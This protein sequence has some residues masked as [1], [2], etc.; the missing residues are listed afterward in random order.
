MFR[1]QDI[2]RDSPFGS[3]HVRARTIVTAILVL[4]LWGGCSGG[5]TVVDTPSSVLALETLR[6]NPQLRRRL[7]L[8]MR[9]AQGDGHFVVTSSPERAARS[10]VKAPARASGTSRIEDLASEDAWLA[11]KPLERRDVPATLQDAIV[12]YENAQEA[13]DVVAV[14]SDG[15]M[16]E[17]QI[18]RSDAAPTTTQ[19]RLTHGTG[20]SDISMHEGYV[21]ARTPD[22]RIFARTTP[23]VAYDSSQASLPVDVTLEPQ[24][25]D[26]IASVTVDTSNATFPVALD[27]EWVAGPGWPDEGLVALNSIL[28]EGGSNVMVGDVAVIDEAPGLMLGEREL[29]LTDD[30]SI[31]GSVYAH[32]VLIESE[33]V[34]IDNDVFADFVDCDPQ[35]QAQQSACYSWDS[36]PDGLPVQVTTPAFPAFAAGTGSETWSTWGTKQPGVYGDVTIAADVGIYLEPGLY[37]MKSLTVGTG[38]RLMLHYGSVEVRIE[39]SLTLADTARFY[40]SY[41]ADLEVFV[42]GSND[43]PGDPWSQPRAVTIG[44]QTY[45]WGRLFAPNGTIG[46]ETSSIVFGRLVGRDV[47]VGEDAYIEADSQPTLPDCETFCQQVMTAG[48]CQDGPQDQQECE[49][50]CYDDLTTGWCQQQKQMFVNCV[51]AAATPPVFTCVGGGGKPVLSPSMAC[52]TVEADFHECENVCADLPDDPGDCT[53]SECHCSPAQCD[54]QNP[55]ASWTTEPAPYGTSCDNG[56]LCD[57]K[58]VCNGSGQCQTGTAVPVPADQPPCV[59]YTCDAATGNV[60]TNY[61]TAACNDGDPCTENDACDGAGHC[62]GTPKVGIEDADPMT[63]DLC[64]PSTGSISHPPVTPIDESVSTNTYDAFKHLFIDPD[65][66][67]AYDP[68]QQGVAPGAIVP[69]HIAVVRGFVQDVA[70]HALPGVTVRVLQPSEAP[71]LGSTLTQ[72]DGQFELA[73]NG[74]GQVTIEYQKAGYPTLQRHVKTY[75]LDISVAP[76]VVMTRYDPAGTTISFDGS[77]QSIQIARS[78]LNNDPLGP[79]QSTLLFHPGTTAQ[80]TF[81]DGSPPQT[82][83]AGTVRSTEYTVGATGPAAMPGT[84]PEASAYTLAYEAS[85][86]E[87]VAAGASG[88]SFNIPV[89][90]YVENF[91]EAPVGAIVPLGYYDRTEGHWEEVPGGLV[92]KIL[93]DFDQDGYCELD[94]DG[95]DAPD[96]QAHLDAFEITDNERAALLGLYSPG[97]TVWRVQL[98]HF[99]PDDA[100]F[101]I[102]ADPD[103]CTPGDGECP[104]GPPIA[105]L[106]TSDPDCQS[107]SIIECQNQVL[108]ESIPV[109]GTP[110]SLNYR[111]DRTMGARSRYRIDIP[112]VGVDPLPDSVIGIIAEV[113]VAG[114]RHEQLFDCENATPDPECLP[115][116]SWAFEWDGKDYKQRLVQGPQ[117]ATVRTGYM[118]RVVR[119]TAS[120][121]AAI[122]GGGSTSGGGPGEGNTGLAPIAGG[123]AM[124][125]GQ[126]LPNENFLIVDEGSTGPLDWWTY[127]LMTEPVRVMVGTWRSKPVGLG[128]WSLSPHHGYA[129]YVDGL[130]RGDGRWRLGSRLR[131]SLALTAGTDNTTL[132]QAGDPLSTYL[133]W[134]AGIDVAPD[135]SI[136][137]A[138]HPSSGTSTILKL[139]SERTAISIDAGG[140]G[141]Y[142]APDGYVDT[143]AFDARFHLPY[144]VAVGPDGSRYVADTFNH[145]I[146][147]IDPAGVVTTIAGGPLAQ[148][149]LL[150]P[151]RIEHD[152][153]ALYFLEDVPGPGVAT[154]IRRLSPGGTLWTVAGGGAMSIG[155]YLCRT[156]C[157][158]A[159][160]SQSLCGQLPA[161][162]IGTQIL[163]F[164]ATERGLWW[165]AQTTEC[166][167]MFSDESGA[168]RVAGAGSCTASA[169]TDALSTNLNATAIAVDDRGSKQ[170]VFVAVGVGIE[171]TD[172]GGPAV[173]AI[174]GLHEPIETVTGGGCSAGGSGSACGLDGP[175][176]LAGITNGIQ[177][178]EVTPDGALILADSY[179]KLFEVRA[180]LGKLG[181]HRVPS[182]DGGRIFEFAGGRH[183]TTYD[184]TVATPLLEFD[185]TPDKRLQSVTDQD[186]HA[187][188]IAYGP[189]QT[190]ITGPFGHETVLTLDANGYLSTVQN[191]DG[192]TYKLTH[193]AEGR[194]V[195]VQYPNSYDSDPNT[196]QKTYGYSADDFFLKSATGPEGWYKLLQ[197]T[198]LG[199]SHHQVKV[200]NAL[201]L[202]TTYD[203]ARDDAG[204]YTYTTTGKDGVV[205][206]RTD[207][208]D[209]GEV[210]EFEA[211]GTTITTSMANDERFGAAAG[212][213]SVTIESGGLSFTSVSTRSA[214]LQDESDPL[215]VETLTETVEVNGRTTTR[216]TDRT[217]TPTPTMASMVTVT[218]EANRT[219][220][221]ELDPDGRPTKVT[222]PV[223]E[224]TTVQYYGS[225]AHV[226]KVHIVTEGPGHPEERS[227]TYIYDASGNVQSVTNPLNEVQTYTYDSVGRLASITYD[228]QNKVRF[229]YDLNGNLV[230]LAQPGTKASY[231]DVDVHRFGYTE[232]DLLDW[233]DPPGVAGDPNVTGYDYRQD[234][235]PTLMDLPSIGKEPQVTYEYDPN[236]GQLATVK[237]TKDYRT[238]TYYPLGDGSGRDGKLETV[239]SKQDNVTITYDY[240]G[241]LPTS[242]AWSGPVSG[243]VTR[244]FNNDFLIASE[245]V[246]GDAVSYLYDD[247]DGLLTQAGQATLARNTDTGAMDSVTVGQL[248]DAYTPNDFGELDQIESGYNATDVKYSVDYDRDKLG[249]VIRRTETVLND[250][251]VV[252]E[253]TYDVRGRL[254]H[255]YEGSG[256]CDPGPCTLIE[257]YGYDANDNRTLVELNG[258]SFKP[259]YDEQDRLT[260]HGTNSYTYDANGSLESKTTTAGHTTYSYD[261]L[262]ALRQVDPPGSSNTIAYVIDGVGRRIG[263]KVGGSLERGWIYRDGL[264]PVAEVGS[265]GT[266]MTARFVYGS[267]THV[268]DYM[269][270]GGST[271]RFVTDHLG[272][273]RLVVDV[274]TGS[275]AQRI[276]YDAWGMPTFSGPQPADFQPF[277]FA[278][279][280]YDPDT[281]LYR[282]GARDYDPEVGRWTTKDPIRFTGGQANL[283][284]YAGGD[285]VNRID[286]NGRFWQFVAGAGL[287]AVGGTAG[288]IAGSLMSGSAITAQG[289]GGAAAGGAISG[290]GVAS[291]TWIIGAAAGAL[292]SVTSD[293][294]GGRDVSVAAAGIG[295]FTGGIATPNVDALKAAAGPDALHS[296]V[297]LFSGR[298]AATESQVVE[299]LMFDALV[300]SGWKNAAGRSASSGCGQAWATAVVEQ[301]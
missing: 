58:E 286:P 118:Y 152:G 7:D 131:P 145:A 133:G 195:H 132:P 29:S 37:H 90:A 184:A 235:M 62:V 204:L 166:Y 210:V 147:K 105:S 113:T 219:F 108:G 267:R 84:L 245:T 279:G 18:L 102:L 298:L 73:V 86:D 269:E 51:S 127:A 69:E 87:A 4:L 3:V 46:I 94:L 277:G 61:T 186:G 293:L 196:E 202:F 223:F 300:K 70:G 182:D 12:V 97:E 39:E 19:Y 200:G 139:D 33:D 178:L 212:V 31:E 17:L 233:Y 262:G 158:P 163:D 134:V 151:R 80:M 247:D 264:N 173:L 297:S 259:D 162:E 124:T 253:Y 289:L 34:N 167:V 11:I 227:Y 197:R 275:V 129:S 280:L 190:T 36:L 72:M 128:G 40:S 266:T 120:V 117:P 241:M 63:M 165:T 83:T 44:N 119:A 76:M 238:L 10:V 6:E 213:P 272:S 89:S 249:R 43:T 225:G 236:T 252:H 56:S 59:T 222:P 188:T 47:H 2:T 136:Y 71:S 288:Y 211:D 198:E 45:F 181:T 231:N 242:E 268:P 192:G 278:G 42:E 244:G 16:E 78:S 75:W 114:Q 201:A 159:C 1:L 294:I 246:L 109:A 149:P 64:D 179:G 106:N 170:R 176:R 287:G 255:V 171:D 254:T 96:P 20:I 174:G 221:T 301:D 14:L 284:L 110:F 208:L 292:G 290:L 5:G 101:L 66:S 243:T 121:T 26:Y 256:P 248:V 53:V 265:D 218:T 48:P 175:A 215:S 142:A 60:E 230:T 27:P 205:R 155:G 203:M 156:E 140:A 270:K 185:Y 24:G 260:T 194:L 285:P 169:G 160:E 187:T 126:W 239:S 214:T 112:L 98:H 103:R 153:T 23:V 135:G 21:V 154:R 263:K 25:E 157:M 148:V 273:V 257:H 168:G 82:L 13:T 282:F 206:K 28:F 125:F 240:A 229:E 141:V 74:G 52:T 164:D 67:D 274:A 261:D 193:D 9:P 281:G 234:L 32:E 276:D 251:T 146:R 209:G 138:T 137:M 93:G 15:R 77:T 68:P 130:Y 291:G 55:S 299:R 107:G 226:G 54:E 85:I 228:D 65:P 122:G 100:N 35:G 92:L 217:V 79:R 295:A 91:Y 250:P 224:P 216:V 189:M 22:G 199:D 183:V 88:V 116:S 177:D 150:Y 41:P 30:A 161:T 220:S 95:D 283:Y 123:Q 191:P 232:H 180:P 57:G 115:E 81:A 8:A 258:A 207:Q 49:D 237:L 99:S 143:T 296:A 271:Y 144:D 111:S 172:F 38:A 50:Q 104:V